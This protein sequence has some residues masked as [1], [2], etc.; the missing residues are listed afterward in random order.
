MKKLSI[1]F[2][3]GSSVNYTIKEKVSWEQYFNRHSK[4]NM[5]SAIL[6]QSPYNK[7][8]PEI[9]VGQP[10][11]KDLKCPDCGETLRFNCAKSMKGILYHRYIC[12]NYKTYHNV[13][14][15]HDCNKCKNISITEDKQN[16]YTDKPDHICNA[17]NCRILH[18]SNHPVL[19]PLA[20]CL[21]NNSFEPRED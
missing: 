18:R 21:L 8:E 14:V 13:K 16:E 1:I 11:V 6:Y 20:K 3:D 12:P 9:L 19:P 2:T 5:S 4:L 7:N 17:Y 10:P 15:V